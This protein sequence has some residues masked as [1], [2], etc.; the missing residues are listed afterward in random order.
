MKAIHATVLPLD[1][2]RPGVSDV[3]QGND[4][5]FEIGVA[6]A[7]RT[8]IPMSPWVGKG[9]VTAENADRAIPVTPPRILHV[10]MVNAV[11]KSSDELDVINPLVPQVRRVIIKAKTLVVFDGAQGTL[12]AC[13][14]ESDLSR[15]NFQGEVGVMFLEFFQDR[16]EPLG[17]VLKPFFPVGLI[18]RGKA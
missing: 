6:S 18:R 11:G 8:K 13:Y 9:R 2:K 12:G 1:G 15:V 7:Y 10:G 16:S 3:V 14:V 4:N 5:F 17:K